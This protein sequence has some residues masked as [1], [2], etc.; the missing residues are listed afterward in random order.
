MTDVEKKPGSEVLEK[1]RPKEKLEDLWKVVFH[2]DDYT[3]MQFVVEVL[4]DVFDR[5]PAEAYR[6]MM[7][8]HVEGRGIAGVYTHEVAETKAA[9]TID[10]ARQAGF[11]LFASVEEG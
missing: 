3:P 2:N 10:L 7:Q 5:T 9:T 6:I 4:E 1:P 11:P 8:V